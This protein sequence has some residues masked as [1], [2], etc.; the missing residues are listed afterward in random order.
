MKPRS[1]APPEAMAIA[2]DTP[3][4]ATTAGIASEPPSTT[5]AVSLVAAVAM[6]ER[7]MSSVFRR[8]DAYAASDPI[9]TES[10][11][12]I[13]PVAA[14]QTDGSHNLDQSGLYMKLSP[15]SGLLVVAT[16]LTMT[17][18]SPSVSTRTTRIAAKMNS[19]G[20]PILASRSMP[21]VSP[22]LTTQKLTAMV[23][24]KKM[25]G[26]QNPCTVP[27]W[28]LTYEPKNARIPASSSPRTAPVSEKKV[29]ARVHDSM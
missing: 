6:P 26:V 27:F 25:N 12:K 5:S 8:Y 19:S 29:Q 15:S 22:W 24:K 3:K 18:W 7:A 9:P 17:V 2:P 14:S 4:N 28:R 1:K 16:P 23:M 11:K 10:V 13:C 20:M 21:L